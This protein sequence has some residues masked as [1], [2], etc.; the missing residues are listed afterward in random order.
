[1]S[2]NFDETSSQQD[3]SESSPE[4]ASNFNSLKITTETSSSVVLEWSYATP[5]AVDPSSEIVF[6]LLKLETRDDWKA[7]AW[8]RKMTCKIENLEQNVCYSLQLLALVAN[9]DGFQVVDESDVFKV[10]FV[11]C[12]DSSRCLRDFNEK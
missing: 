10:S 4:V 9:D 11:Y 8:T 2:E 6:K 1:M 7:I 3:L 5:Q 12:E